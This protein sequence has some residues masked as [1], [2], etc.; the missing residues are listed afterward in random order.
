MSVILET[1]DGIYKYRCDN[2]KKEKL[3]KEVVE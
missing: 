2:F 1:Q 3:K